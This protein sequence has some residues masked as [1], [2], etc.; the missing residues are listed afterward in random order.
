MPEKT[1]KRI[2]QEQEVL[3][4][5]GELLPYEIVQKTGHARRAVM[6][7]LKENGYSTTNRKPKEPE[8]ITEEQKIIIRELYIGTPEK[9]PIGL[10]GITAVLWLTKKTVRDYLESEGLLKPKGIRP[11]KTNTV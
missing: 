2:K 7:I 1:P 6:S 10:N 9:G 3:T 8:V 5:A 11:K 4:H